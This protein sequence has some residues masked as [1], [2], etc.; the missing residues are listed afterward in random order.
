MNI[1][2]LLIAIII[3]GIGLSGAYLRA[4]YTFYRRHK[5]VERRKQLSLRELHTNRLCHEENDLR[6]RVQPEKHLD[7]N[8]ATQNSGRG[9]IP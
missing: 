5:A 3:G 6:G 2:D 4:E 8:A 9:V 7:P 1:D